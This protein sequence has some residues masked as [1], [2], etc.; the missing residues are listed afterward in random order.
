MF[1]AESSAELEEERRLAYVAITRAKKRLYIIH[2]R[3][4]MLYG[5]TGVNALSRFVKEIP[6]ELLF[7]E[8]PKPKDYGYNR[9]TSSNSGTKVYF[10]ERQL[11]ATSFGMKSDVSKA[12]STQKFSPGDRVYHATFG[13]GDILS[14]KPMGND[15]LYEVVFDKVGTKKLMGNFARLK[16]VP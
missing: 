4:R 13:V 10:S 7:N 16:Q 6:D 8:T 14:A 5:K 15:V 12:Q 1:G 3:T 11:D 9:Q 2:T